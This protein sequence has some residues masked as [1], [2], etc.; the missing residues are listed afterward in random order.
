MELW[1]IYDN[2]RRKT[3]QVHLRGEILGPGDYHLA[4][5]I[6][7]YNGDGQILITKRAQEKSTDPGRWESTVGSV[8][9]GEESLEGACRELY[10]ETGILAASQDMRLIYQ[11]HGSG[12][13]GG[14][15][16]DIYIVKTDAPPGQIRLQPGE[17][18]DARWIDAAK[19]YQGIRTDEILF[20]GREE[21]GKIADTV[22]GIMNTKE[23]E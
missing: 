7:V 3:G 9:A 19:W 13:S 5:G 16:I 6:V 18:C 17:T 4:V 23:N 10:E 22:M 21:K 2:Q 8:M 15:L 20:L 11:T 1:D 14:A 12:Y